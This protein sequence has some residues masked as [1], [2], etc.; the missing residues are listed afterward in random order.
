MKRILVIGTG[1]IGERHTRCM[2]ATR[3]ATVG[4]CELNPDI[5]RRVAAQ[6][7]LAESFTSLD[8]A[9][10]EPWDAAVIATPAHTHVPI[11][12]RLAGRGIHLLIE[13]PLSTSTDGIAELTETVEQGGLHAGVA[14]VYR[15]HPG[16][17]AMRRALQA[18]RFGE[19]VQVV[20]NCGQNFPFFRPAYREIYYTDRAKGGGAIQ[21]ALTHM[22]NASE[23]LVGPVER[24]TADADHMVLEGVTVE[25]T[26]H[27]LTRHGKV[28]G[29]FSLNQYQPPNEIL[30][31]VNCTRGTVR[32][33]PI[34]QRWR[35]QTDP[36]DT[37]HDEPWSPME[38]DDLFTLQAG[39][40]LDVLE[41]KAAPLCT[42]AEG[43]QTLRVN[44][45]ALRAVDGE[46]IWLPVGND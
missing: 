8:T 33:E 39:A 2:L 13:K 28:M 19:P 7:G 45:A 9:L 17:A 27:V 5:C 11:A 18:G 29:S 43:L 4:I 46:A 37:W 23:W 36:D 41:E 30:L 3:R 40:F 12:R 21:D 26:V 32:F 42:L 15:A 20:V 6:Y 1:S 10:E 14:Y 31:T 35:W 22:V 44:L 38:R 25:D 34:G 16:L 24:L